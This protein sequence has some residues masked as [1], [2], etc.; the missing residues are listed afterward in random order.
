MERWDLY[1]ENNGGTLTVGSLSAIS[2]P[3]SIVE[4][5]YGTTL[6]LG[7]QS[8]TPGEN[9]IPPLAPWRGGRSSMAR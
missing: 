8:I 1:A 2:A 4:L 7:G 5:E 6:D 3:G 9:G